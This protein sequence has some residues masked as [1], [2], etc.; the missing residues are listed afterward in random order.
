M[1]VKMYTHLKE[2]INKDS[3]LTLASF[4]KK[5]WWRYIAKFANLKISNQLD[6]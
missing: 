1:A 4:S 6:I 2:H 5:F 3:V